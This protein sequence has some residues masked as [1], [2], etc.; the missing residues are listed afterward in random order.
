MPLSAEK[1]AIR[2]REILTKRA[3]SFLELA[4]AAFLRRDATFAANSQ[5]AGNRTGKGQGHE[6]S[7]QCF[8]RGA[9]WNRTS[10]LHIISVT[11]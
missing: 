11:L 5:Q 6:G 3:Q 1:I 7:T 10:D 9:S 8:H 2:R 4:P